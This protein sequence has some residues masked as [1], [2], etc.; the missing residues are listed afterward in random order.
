MEFRDRR[1]GNPGQPIGSRTVPPLGV[2]GDVVNASVDGDVRRH[3]VNW[4]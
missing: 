2:I 3:P 4:S 1:Q